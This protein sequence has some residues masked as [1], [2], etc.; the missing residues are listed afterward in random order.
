MAANAGIRDGD[1]VKFPGWDLPGEDQAYYPDLKGKVSDLKRILLEKQ[2]HLF[3]AFNTNGSFKSLAVL[4]F[5]KF[6]KSDS[7]LYFRVEYPGYYFVQG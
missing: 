4:D 1:F 3:L 6:Q 7:D 5:S 2:G